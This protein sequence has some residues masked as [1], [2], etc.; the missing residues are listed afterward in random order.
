MAK[1]SKQHYEE[2]A[3]LLNENNAPDALVGR[4]ADAFAADNPN[5]DRMRFL[6]AATPGDYGEVEEGNPPD[7]AP[8]AT[9]DVVEVQPPISDVMEE[10]ANWVEHEAETVADAAEAIAEEAEDKGL[11]DAADEV[12]EAGEEAT[13]A[14]E[15]LA[16]KMEDARE[17]AADAEPVAE[18][19]EAVEDVET[20]NP[21]NVWQS[22]IGEHLIARHSWEWESMEGATEEGL[23]AMHRHEHKQYQD[24]LDHGAEIEVG[25]PPEVEP[26]IGDVPA[27]TERIAEAPQPTAPPDAPPKQDHWAYRPLMRR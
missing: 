1:F 17:E 12:R 13:E 18:V 14:V 27:A 5:F 9:V 24:T 2:I 7:V 8:V 21:P 10:V 4:M 20:G 23:S 16:E 11:E 3:K 15:E 22:K 6:R 26:P 25:N 19:E